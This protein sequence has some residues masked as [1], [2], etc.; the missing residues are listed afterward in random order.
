M[1]EAATKIILTMCILF[2]IASLL[3]V[4]G[5]WDKV[6]IIDDSILYHYNTTHKNLAYPGDEIEIFCDGYC[7]DYYGI[8]QSDGSIKL[9]E[10]Q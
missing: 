5:I 8:M 10:R 2:C 7:D 1:K 6:N 3:A 9:I 4:Y